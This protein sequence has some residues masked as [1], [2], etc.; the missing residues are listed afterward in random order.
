MRKHECPVEHLKRLASASHCGRA[1]QSCRLRCFALQSALALSNGFDL[2][3][4]RCTTTCPGHCVRMV[5][6]YACLFTRPAAFLLS[7]NLRSAGVADHIS[8][9]P[10]CS[11]RCRTPRGM[12]RL[13]VW[14]FRRT[15][16]KHNSGQVG[17]YLL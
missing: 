14:S 16:V 3:P 15:S 2:P 11:S 9:L 17:T 7:S 10:S 4:T 5:N 13:M 12:E 1:F 6:L 8:L